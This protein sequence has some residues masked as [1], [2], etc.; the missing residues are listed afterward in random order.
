M[1]GPLDLHI[2]RCVVLQAAVTLDFLTVWW[3][4][5]CVQHLGTL[6]LALTSHDQQTHTRHLCPLVHAYTP[7]RH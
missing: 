6:H 5:L 3:A 4:A 1:S 2:I 7:P